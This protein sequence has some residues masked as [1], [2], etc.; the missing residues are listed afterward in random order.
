MARAA[1]VAPGLVGSV[2]DVR[3]LIAHHLGH[4]SDETPALAVGW[5]AEVVG[6]VIDRLLDGELAIRITD[7]NSNQPL[8]FEPLNSDPTPPRS[9]S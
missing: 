1:Q 4:E 5:R 9:Y 3:D 7:P 6:Q 8:S 2:Q